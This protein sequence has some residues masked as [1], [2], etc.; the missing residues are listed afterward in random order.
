MT[1]PVLAATSGWSGWALALV[2]V[3]FVGLAGVI[4]WRLVRDHVRVKNFGVVVPGKIFRAG[5]LTPGSLRILHK[6]HGV[7]TIIDLGA[8]TAGSPAERSME[9]AAADLGLS[10]VRFHGLKGDGTGDP[11]VYL[12]VLRLLRDEERAPVVVH[13]AAG[14]DRTGALVMLYR[15]IEQGRPLED[16]IEEART[17]R[18]NPVKNPRMLAFVRQH[19]AAIASALKLGGPLPGGGGARRDVTSERVGGDV[20]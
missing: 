16:C 5:R 7:R 11:E 14:A 4:A 19:A 1:S 2:I 3:E 10:R 9:R 12:E 18:H 15:S 13:C 8:E 6:R 20:A 17:H